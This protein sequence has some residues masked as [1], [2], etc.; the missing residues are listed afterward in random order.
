[1]SDE[2]G[3]YLYEQ[4]TDWYH[5]YYM[6]INTGVIMMGEEVALLK[7]PELESQ[8]GLIFFIL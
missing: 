6:C 4:G 2:M 5:H 1:M 7:R 3:L 8:R